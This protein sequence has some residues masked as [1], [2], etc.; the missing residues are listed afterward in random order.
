MRAIG[1]PFVESASRS[2]RADDALLE[3]QPG[4]VIAN[5]SCVTRSLRTAPPTA[6]TFISAPEQARRLCLP[7]CAPECDT[8]SAQSSTGLGELHGYWSFG[9]PPMVRIGPSISVQLRG[10]SAARSASASAPS[11]QRRRP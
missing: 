3:R 1:D 2:T 9:G 4:Y 11:G 6:N 10:S 5:G 7:A 8:S